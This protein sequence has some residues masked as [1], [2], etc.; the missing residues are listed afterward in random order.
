MIVEKKYSIDEKL[1]SYCG[2]IVWYVFVCFLLGFINFCFFLGWIDVI[3]D[4]GGLNFYR[5]GVEGKFDFKFVLGYDFDIV[6]LFK[7]VL[8]IVLGIT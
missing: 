7:F 5:M 1:I 8:F 4:V 2:V 3:W 6:V